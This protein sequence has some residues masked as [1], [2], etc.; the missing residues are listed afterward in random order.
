MTDLDFVQRKIESVITKGENPSSEII[1]QRD[2]F[3][4]LIEKIGTIKE[5]VSS[6]ENLWDPEDNL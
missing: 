2:A 5:N 3:I 1:E 6:L 4:G